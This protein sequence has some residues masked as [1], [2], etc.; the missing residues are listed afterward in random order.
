M[1]HGNKQ[2]EKVVE[3]TFVCLVRLYMSTEVKWRLPEEQGGYTLSTKRNWKREL[4]LMASPDC[5]GSLSVAIIEPHHVRAYFDGIAHLPGKCRLALAALKQLEAWAVVRQYLPRQITLGVKVEQATSGHVPWNQKQVDLAV[6]HARPDFVRVVQ[7]ANYTGQRVSDLIRMCPT[8]VETIE[9][10]D[11]INVRQKKTHKQ[12]WIPIMSELAAIMATWERRPG[13]FLI[14]ED[15]SAWPSEDALSNAWRR[16]REGNP[17]LVPLG[18]QA[19]KGKNTKDKGLVFHGLRATACVNL[20]NAGSTAEHI[21]DLV[22]MS[23][24]M[25]EHYCRLSVQ[26]ENALH[27][28]ASLERARL[29]RAAR[30]RV[31]P[32]TAAQ[33]IIK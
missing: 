31:V 12:V 14:R 16:E 28:V 1:H 27:A 10:I 11:G 9:G 18:A 19:V 22:G 2:I 3:D 20:R 15:G 32:V 26:K 8:D 13:P 17:A 6:A 29:E 4:D 7:L 30:Q 25:V 5:L 33:G 24:P 23:V 21:A